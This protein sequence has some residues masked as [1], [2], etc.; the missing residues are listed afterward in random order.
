MFAWHTHHSVPT[1][2]LEGLLQGEAPSVS[3]ALQLLHILTNAGTRLRVPVGLEKQLKDTEVDT[4][5]GRS[6]YQLLQVG[7]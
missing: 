2:F 6:M 3:A 7:V 5:V 1:Q 4:E